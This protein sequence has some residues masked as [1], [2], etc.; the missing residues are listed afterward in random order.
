MKF[1]LVYTMPP[2]TTLKMGSLT[3]DE[4]YDADDSPTGADVPSD[5]ISN[6]IKQFGEKRP[7]LTIVSCTPVGVSQ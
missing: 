3:I 4:V 5:V 7:D 6:V 1:Y 2:D